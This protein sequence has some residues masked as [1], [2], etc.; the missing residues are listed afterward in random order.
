MHTRSRNRCWLLG[1]IVLSLVC[2]GCSAAKP[3]A[4]APCPC[5]QAI[6]NLSSQAKLYHQALKDKGMLREQLKNCERR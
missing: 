1:A 4:A 3:K 5:Q 2:A 6:D